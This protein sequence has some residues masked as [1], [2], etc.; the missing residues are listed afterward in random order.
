VTHQGPDG[1]P[2]TIEDRSTTLSDIARVLAEALAIPEGEL[3]EIEA[4][5]VESTALELPEGD[6]A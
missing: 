4:E 1:G 6:A 5:I 3:R 2:I